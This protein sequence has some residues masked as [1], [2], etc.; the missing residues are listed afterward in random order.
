MSRP[1]IRERTDRAL[2]TVDHFAFTGIS[3][4]QH[5][6]S[7]LDPI[8]VRTRRVARFAVLM[9]PRTRPGKFAPDREMQSVFRFEPGSFAEC[10]GGSR[11]GGFIESENAADRFETA[12]RFCQ[13]KPG[14][15]FS[16]PDEMIGND[17]VGKIIRE[18]NIARV[19]LMN[20]DSCPVKTGPGEAFSSLGHFCRI[21]FDA[22]NLQI[23]SLGQLVGKLPVPGSQHEAKT[24]FDSRAVDDLL[25]GVGVFFSGII[26]ARGVGKRLS[27]GRGDG[28]TGAIRG[29]TD[30]VAGGGRDDQFSVRDREAP[31]FAFDRRAPDFF[32]IG[33]AIGCDFGF[34]ARDQIFS[35]H[36]ETGFVGRRN[37]P[38]KSNVSQGPELFLFD[39]DLAQKVFL[40]LRLNLD[41]RVEFFDLLPETITN[42]RVFPVNIAVHFRNLRSVGDESRFSVYRHLM[43]GKITVTDFSVN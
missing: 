34:P 16:G 9:R 7:A 14:G 17:E 30:D 22:V 28:F 1:L 8:V 4:P 21:G 29:K 25:R 19:A 10:F 18:G 40:F 31:S 12:D 42:N 41:S 37:S 32:A 23:G 38:F 3:I 20:R 2:V 15:Q 36:D 24:A 13:I 43:T 26:V 11:G 5:A 39:L 27:R 35:R 33:D 6:E